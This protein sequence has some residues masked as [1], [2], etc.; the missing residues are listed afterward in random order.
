MP[1][2][3][4]DPGPELA[5]IETACLGDRR[6]P[7][8]AVMAAARRVP[9]RSLGHVERSPTLYGKPRPGDTP[10]CR[11]VHSV[12]GPIGELDPILRQSLHPLAREC[13][14]GRRAA[15]HAHPDRHPSASRPQ[16][17][18]ARRQIHLL[19]AEN[20]QAA[21]G[22]LSHTRGFHA[23]QTRDIFL[24]TPDISRPAERDAEACSPGVRT[25]EDL[26]V[27]AGSPYSMVVP[28]AQRSSPRRLGAEDVH[29]TCSRTPEH[30]R[31][32]ESACTFLRVMSCRKT[33]LDVHTVGSRRTARHRSRGRAGCSPHSPGL[34]GTNGFPKRH[35][36]NT[37]P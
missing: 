24:R 15:R 12:N 9:C 20:E 27:S 3:G 17:A 35:P 7:I 36:R 13:T 31:G 26:R 33:I 32:A 1:R 5:F 29:A 14:I 21:H 25:H 16:R 8:N 6:K 30:G 37:L 2:G 11:G 4:L 19:S 22:P 23:E 18:R 10:A 34:A 28:A